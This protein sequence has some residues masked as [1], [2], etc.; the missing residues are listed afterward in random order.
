MNRSQRLLGLAELPQLSVVD[1]LVD[2][3]R[4]SVHVEAPPPKRE[5]FAW[6]KGFGHVQR[7][8]NAIPKGNRCS[9]NRSWSQLNTVLSTVRSCFGRISFRAGVFSA[10]SCS[11]A[12]SKIAFM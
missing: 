4:P 12:S 9:T 11:M 1:S 6:S 10:N 2:S 7:E 5:Q 8:Q 3:Q